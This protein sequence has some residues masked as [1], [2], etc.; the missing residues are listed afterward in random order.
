MPSLSLPTRK[1]FLH[2]RQ[3]LAA[4][5]HDTPN[6]AENDAV[7]GIEIVERIHVRAMPCRSDRD[8]PP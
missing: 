5:M 6:V 8:K 1:T 7:P 2:A 3:Q 4:I